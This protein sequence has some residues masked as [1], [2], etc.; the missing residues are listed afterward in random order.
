[1]LIVDD[2]LA[3]GEAAHALIDIVRQAGGKVAGIAV[4]I[5]KGQQNGGKMLREEGYRLESIA[6]VDSMDWESQTIRFRAKN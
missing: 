3:E 4:C 5:E 1:V 6:I 2:F